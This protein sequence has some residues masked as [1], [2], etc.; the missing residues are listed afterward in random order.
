MSLSVPTWIAAIATVA[1]AVG[2]V[3]GAAVARKALSAHVRQLAAQ[4]ELTRQLAE[5]IQLQ[6]QNLRVALDERRRAQACQVFIEL[7]R[8]GAAGSPG[9]AP[10]PEAAMVAATVHNNSHQPI[11]DLYVIWLLGT[12]RMGKPDPAAKLL[13]GQQVCF[14]R[15][16]EPAGVSGDG[17]PGASAGAGAGTLTAFLTFRDAAGVRW[18]VREDGT[19]SDISP[20]PDVR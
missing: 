5:A 19:L 11:Y 13:P 4:H 14:E 10:G 15:A 9:Q 7:R 1:L 3:A 20:A 8:A 18:T 6:S 12:T 16:P 17:S 2:V